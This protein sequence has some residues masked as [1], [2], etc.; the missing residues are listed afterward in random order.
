ME[1]T[2]EYLITHIENLQAQE[3]QYL[4]LANSAH[5]AADFARHMLAQLEAEVRVAQQAIAAERPNALTLEQLGLSLG[6]KVEKPMQEV[7]PDNDGGSGGGGSGKY[8]PW[9][10]GNDTGRDGDCHE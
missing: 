8:G 5:G 6:A 3:T 4:A 2:R 7:R 1:V 10:I 9:G